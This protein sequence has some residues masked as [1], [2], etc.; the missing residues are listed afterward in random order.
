MKNLIA[1][2]LIFGIGISCGQR[3]NS[4]SSSNESCI[5]LNNK[6]HEYLMNFQM[7]NQNTALRDSAKVYFFQSHC[8]DSNYL[9]P[10]Y[11]LATL[12]FENQQLDSCLKYL[13][14]LNQDGVY[15]DP[16]VTAMQAIC[17]KHIHKY[18]EYL[19]KRNLALANSIFEFH[20]T[21]NFDKF[22]KVIQ[23][24]QMIDGNENAERFY[25]REKHLVRD[26][27]EY[28][29]IQDVLKSTNSTN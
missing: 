29:H 25:D 10:A 9:A 2:A 16:L 3:H 1:V 18:E 21:R 17:L 5:D 27:P 22:L 11:N 28:F 7:S 14:K 19:A 26:L 20:Q 6:G 23:I 24:I 4:L 15:H 13:N 8:C 12:Y